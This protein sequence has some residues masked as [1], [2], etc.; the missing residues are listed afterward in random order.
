MNPR[1]A[2]RLLI[3]AIDSECQHLAVNANL[4]KTLSMESGR[5]AREK[6]ERLRKTKQVLTT[7]V[8]E[9]QLDWIIDMG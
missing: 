8:Q 5:H 7:L 4:Y 2:V 6:R 9:W 1:Q 3:E